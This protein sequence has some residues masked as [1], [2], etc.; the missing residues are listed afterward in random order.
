MTAV[1]HAG[2]SS[3]SQSRMITADGI[4]WNIVDIGEGPAVLLVHGTAASVH[5]WR[6]VVPIVSRNHRIICLDL[7]GHGLSECR[8]SSDL[9]LDRMA[10]GIAAVLSVLGASPAVVAGHSAG[11]AI[12]VEAAARKLLAPSK[13]I[14][15]NGAF[16]PFAGVAGS[17]FSPIAKLFAMNP[18]VPKVLAGV[19]SRATVERL[20]RDTG[21]RPSPEDVDEYFRLFRQPSHVSAALGMMAAW[22]LG[23]MP[24]SL[25]R[26]PMTCIFVAGDNDKA[27]PP[28][29]A[30]RASALCPNGVVL[31]YR[32]YGHLLHEENPKL[33]ASIITGLDG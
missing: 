33:A 4:R 22:N 15:F 16:F 20:L 9:T 18:F 11:A 7:P 2:S 17:L 12:L 32:G 31:H 23:G 30:D 5:T 24:A 8:G 14:S 10:G 27:V 28:S 25:S 21:S 13:L 6:N 26:L 19:A 3:P 29:S 1:S